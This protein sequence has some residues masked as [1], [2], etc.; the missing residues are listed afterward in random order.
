MYRD[1]QFNNTGRIGD[2]SVDQSQK[3]IQNQKMANRLTSNYFSDVLT[4]DQVHFS[5]QQPGLM[6][7]GVMG[8]GISGRL[9]DNESTLMHSKYTEAGK[10]QL[11]E[12][13]F[14]TVPYLGR[15]SCDP[16]LESALQ[17]GNRTQDKKCD[18]RYDILNRHDPANYPF[19]IQVKNIPIEEDNIALK[20]WTRSGYNS[21]N[22]YYD[23]K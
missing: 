17:Q 18:S 10:V 5:T 13:P 12:R 21:H 15:G 14:L 20:G 23:N 6:T 4:S 16:T 3:T 11:F 8:T 2:D 19:N 22:D 7:T 1:Y 9:I